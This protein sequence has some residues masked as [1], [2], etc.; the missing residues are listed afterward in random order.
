MKTT[1][2]PLRAR[3]CLVAAAV[4]T[5]CST[6]LQAQPVLR[7]TH[8]LATRFPESAE[9]LPLGVS[10]VTAD[11]I[12]ASGA[13]TVNEAI[14]RLLGVPGRQDLLGTDDY[15]LDL[16]GFGT[17]ADNNQVVILDGM[18]LNEADLAGT[19]LSGI[20]IESVERIEV[21]R[22]SGAVL[23]GEGAT[24]GVIVITTKAGSGREQ[25]SGGSIYGAAGSHGLSDLR[26]NARVST[27]GGFSLDAHAQNRETD[28]H[29][30]NQMSRLQAG[31]AT[32]QWSNGWLRLGARVAED[33]LDAQLA[34]PLSAAQYAANPRQSVP[35]FDNDRAMVRNERVGVF[36]QA[37]V[38]NWQLGF[39]AAQREKKLRSINFGAPFDYD[40]DATS[41][42][43]RARHESG[44]G[45]AKNALVLGV[46]VNEWKRDILGAFGSEATQR[47]RGFYVKDDV[48]LA[49]GTR[50]SAG[51][52]TERFDKDIASADGTTKLAARQ[53][54]WEL[55]I[56]QPLGAGWTGYARMGRSFRLANVDE[57]SF[58]NPDVPLRPQ[59][60]RDYELG[61]RWGYTG[62]KLEARL[63]RSN[64]TD[65]I[66]F[67]PDGVGPFSAFGFNGS[68]I[69]F[70]PTRR[71][72]LELDWN[73]AL[74]A[75]LGLRVNAALR[76]AKFRSGPHS[77]KD[78]PLVPRQALAVRA[79][80]TPVAGHRVGAG[81]NWVSRQSADFD[82]RCR[83][84]AYTTADA[85][86]AWQFHPQAEFAVGVSN[87]FDRKYYTQAFDCMNGQTTSIYPEAGRQVTASLRV[88]F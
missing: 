72:G 88:R 78:V 50:I 52:R 71:Q 36:A 7:E 81:V 1:V 24:G 58:T 80:W 31:S 63:Y 18:R 77:G 45:S 68:N 85:R 37:D 57:F 28:G 60:S 30:E 87:L 76:D 65:E 22:G 20:P 8:V 70:D 34:G 35:P 79:D 10:V 11:R 44:I 51:V 48:T 54:A 4:A 59:V 39:D 13:A 46:D 69:N 56:S 26:A 6:A 64:I 25:G 61:A 29:R 62:G 66:G 2:H 74:T 53:N 16:R 41:Y 47:S 49:A 43:L 42:G 67:D 27:A 32:G 83:I 38:G 84:P 9:T 12:Q 75:A 5:L 33:K 15:T 14:I 19:R 73:H 86:Y 17:T 21:L 3:A 40:V 82:N 23:Y 55:G